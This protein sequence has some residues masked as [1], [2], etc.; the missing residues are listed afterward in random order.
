MLVNKQ[1]AVRQVRII[2]GYVAVRVGCSGCVRDFC[3]SGS[4]DACLTALLRLR[5]VFVIASRFYVE[6]VRR[7]C[8]TLSCVRFRFI[9]R[10]IVAL[11]VEPWLF[12][13]AMW[14][15]VLCLKNWGYKPQFCSYCMNVWRLQIPTSKKDYVS[16]RAGL[17]VLSCAD[18]FSAESMNKEIKVI[19]LP[20]IHDC[21]SKN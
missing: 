2:L 20:I 17:S 7:L 4:S 15:S 10:F 6:N 18:R 8:C 19:L 12:C 1:L 13:A 14:K 16:P 3:S 9:I 5:N 21:F 11:P